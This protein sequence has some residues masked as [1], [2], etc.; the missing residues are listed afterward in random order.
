M[1]LRIIVHIYIQVDFVRSNNVLFSM[2][3]WF[4]GN[5]EPGFYAE[6]YVPFGNRIETLRPPRQALN[7]GL[8]VEIC[9]R[10]LNLDP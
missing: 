4:L 3:T 8:A 5:L 9:L 6:I 10:L 7:S 2:K 1:S